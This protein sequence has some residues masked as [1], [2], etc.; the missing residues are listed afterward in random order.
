MIDAF[1]YDRQMHLLTVTR[2]EVPWTIAKGRSAATTTTAA[3]A[4]LSC[5]C[6][7]CAATRTLRRGSRL[8]GWCSGRRLLSRADVR[9][10]PQKCREHHDQNSGGEWL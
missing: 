7:R 1:G 4:P 2:N 6:R 9:D 5:T 3:P 8:C 10:E